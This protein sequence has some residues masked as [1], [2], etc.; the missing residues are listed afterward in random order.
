MF[1]VDQS[2]AIVVINQKLVMFCVDQSEV[3]IVSTNQRLVMFYVDQSHRSNVPGGQSIWNTSAPSSRA[4]STNSATD[5][6]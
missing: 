2:E 3:T 1:C 6:L 5:F 4:S